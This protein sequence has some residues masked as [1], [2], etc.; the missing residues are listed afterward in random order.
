MIEVRRN[1][2]ADDVHGVSPGRPSR[3]QSTRSLRVAPM[4]ALRLLAVAVVAM[5]LLAGAPTVFSSRSSAAVL[6]SSTVQVTPIS[7]INT[8]GVH[9]AAGSNGDGWDST[10]YDNNVYVVWHNVTGL[11]VMCYSILSGARCPNYPVT[12]KNGSDTLQVGEN[13]TVYRNS[14]GMLYVYAVDKGNNTAGVAKIDLA[15]GA[16]LS[17]FIALTPSG[18]AWSNAA[19]QTGIS[20]GIIAGSRF[21][22]FNYEPNVTP[23]SGSATDTLLCLNLSTDQ[24][25]ASQ[26]YAVN[27]A[28]PGTSSK[29]VW[30]GGSYTALDAQLA[31]IGTNLLVEVAGYPSSGNASNTSIACTVASSGAPCSGGSWP[32]DIAG[33]DR[34]TW[35]TLYG[36]PYPMLSSTGTVT[37]FCVPT[38]TG[39][40]VVGDSQ[41]NQINCYN[42]SGASAPLASSE[43]S[44]LASAT[45]PE[46]TSAWSGN[47]IVV[48]TEIYMPI[49]DST[50]STTTMVACWNW[51]TTSSCPNYPETLSGAEYMYTLESST[52]DLTKVPSPSNQVCLWEIADNG[53][54]SIAS[55]NPAGG[56][57]PTIPVTEYNL[58]YNT[59]APSGAPAA[60]GSTPTQVTGIT[61][62]STESL[63][64]NPNSLAISG[65]TFGGW[66]ATP[67]GTTPITSVG[68]ITQDQNVYAIWTPVYNLTY[69]V[70]PPVGAPSATGS[71]PSQVTGISPGATQSLANNPNSLAI[72]GYTFGGWSAAPGGTTPIST[73]G[74]INSNQNVYAIWTPQTP[75]GTYTLQ[76]DPNPP[77][78]ATVT[79]GSVP[80]PVTSIAP[81]TSENLESNP[82]SLAISGYT[83]G[84][85]SA[86][87][88]G[89]TPITSV[90]SINSNQ[91]VYAI[92]TP[93]YSL[94]YNVN[95]PSGAPSPTGSVPSQ[96]TGITPGA[97]QSLANNPNSLAIPGYTFGGWSATP[98]GTTP[99][100]SDGPINSNQNVYAIWKPISQSHTYSLTY[101]ANPPMGAGTL[102]G[103]V[104]ANV[105]GIKPGTNKQV[106]GNPNTLAIPGYTFGGWSKTPGGTT[107]ITSVGPINTDENLYA[108]WV[109]THSGVMA[110]PQ[111]HPSPFNTP[112]SGTLAVAGNSS[113][114]YYLVAQPSCG[115]VTVNANGTYSLKPNQN[116]TGSCTFSYLLKGSAG[117]AISTATVI[118]STSL[119]ST[120][121]DARL[122]TLMSFGLLLTGIALL[123]LRLRRYT[124][125][126]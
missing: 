19:Y 5:V 79:G 39:G 27:Y 66:S 9:N 61:S 99:I 55:F 48:G 65:Y 36:K 74:P 119:A 86:T 58:T 42:T 126:K 124:A 114:D 45:L 51:A 31:L 10:V 106:E 115:T 85:W 60:T 3:K 95:P 49:M 125:S 88:G 71:V 67:G 93:G 20:N 96:V 110:N 56:S 16:T 26:P 82:N 113:G 90:N 30:G 50:S 47:A 57:C 73:V 118:I 33:M 70:D 11:N 44:G 91:V 18:S 29:M 123:W 81:G 122:V 23:A 35:N 59:N 80:A 109:P 111:T 43:A 107:P 22:A 13:P 108:I 89:T 1:A 98:G 52:G 69:N 72:S 32:V 105:T 78:G 68:P 40:H 87:Q 120:G 4:R 6:A 34:L 92:W 2:N 41:H 24:A 46:G 112:Y 103:S 104:P 38:S 14:N 117:S 75:S 97:T 64:N 84:G 102:S 94:T 7:T 63:A 25:C 83:F 28:A 100:T 8:V 17:S 121:F 15:T 54:S 76:Y 37:G 101:H 12:V 77:T 62:G 21:Y 53:S 116:F